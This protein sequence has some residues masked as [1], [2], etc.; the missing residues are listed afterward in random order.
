MDKLAF[1][2]ANLFVWK[3]VK[4]SV[5]NNP[6]LNIK[7]RLAALSSSYTRFLISGNNF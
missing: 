4:D 7:M 3:K 6:Y 2:G 1:M 5:V